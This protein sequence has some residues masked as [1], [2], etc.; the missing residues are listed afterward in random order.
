MPFPPTN[1]DSLISLHLP[2]VRV[3]VLALAAA[4]VALPPASMASGAVFSPKTRQAAAARNAAAQWPRRAIGPQR[5]RDRWVAPSLAELVRRS[6]HI[7]AGEVLDTRTSWATHGREIFTTVTLRVDHRL[8]GA[9]G[10]NAVRFRNPGGTMGNFHM[11]VTDSPSFEI[12]ETVLVFLGSQ[13]DRGLST[14]V[15]GEAGK[16]RIRQE[17]DGSWWLTPPLSLEPLLG[18]RS[19]AVLT[20]GDLSAELS[21]LEERQDH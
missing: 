2:P 17:A 8:K 9:A 4:L 19:P 7:V 6:S 1:L 5:T 18:R 3:A 21:R 15:G 11:E 16:R 12:G 13:V 14:V 10:T 20:V